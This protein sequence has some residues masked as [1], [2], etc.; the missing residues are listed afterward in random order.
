F[1]EVDE[2]DWD[3]SSIEEDFLL[4][5]DNSGQK[6][7]AAQKNESNAAS[8]VHAWGL[9][10]KTAPKQEGPPE[11]DNTSTLKSSLVTVTDWSD[12]SDI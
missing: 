6:A 9:P 11:A 7:S 8:V 3:I 12:S 1:T 5:K 4:M 10:K 2:D